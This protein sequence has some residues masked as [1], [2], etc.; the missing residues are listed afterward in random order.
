MRL[1]PLLIFGL[2]LSPP[3]SAVDLNSLS[4]KDAVGG[5]KE[6]LN[7]STSA[8]IG[9]LGIKNGFLGN[10]QVKIPLPSELKTTAAVMQKFGFGSYADELT[11]TMNRAAEA[12][13]P[14]AKP[15]LVKAIKKM[16]VQDAK[17]ILA[18]SDDAATQYFRRTTESQ[19]RAKFLP[20]VTRATHQVGMVE[21]YN[22]FAAKAS[23]FGLTKTPNL[24]QYVT[25]KTLDGL[26]L[27]MK[28]QEKAIRAHPAEY[29]GKLLQKAFGAVAH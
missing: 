3:V 6:A 11:V 18:G 12:A 1:V 28:E 2:A 27:V 8:A 24:D 10:P 25:Q 17:G 5:L 4:N 7:E 16:T 26:F 14:E 13:V 20:I 21:K 23:Q 22:A 9:K 29:S 19:L 15:L